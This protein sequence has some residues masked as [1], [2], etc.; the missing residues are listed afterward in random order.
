MKGFKHFFSVLPLNSPLL[1]VRGIGVRDAMPATMVNRVSGTGDY[2]FA[3]FH[4]AVWLSSGEMPEPSPGG[5]LMIWAPKQWQCYGNRAAPFRHSWMHCDGTAVKRLLAE[6]NLPTGQPLRIPDPSIAERHLLAIFEELTRQAR[7]DVMIVRNELDNMLRETARALRPATDAPAIPAGFL[8]AR[9][10]IE[11]EYERSIPLKELAEKA[12]CS[13]RHFGDMFR[14]HFG[15]PP[16]EYLQR[17]R[18]QR[19]AYLLRDRNLTI[20]GVA[21]CVGYRNIHFFSVAFKRYFG[22]APGAFRKDHHY[23][24]TAAV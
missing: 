4:D 13:V 6:Q 24:L 11:S 3:Y 20:K 22:V 18:L 12:G 19:A 5:T 21:H 23:Q 7:P 9:H 14:R 17:H 10:L 2:L 15:M 8:A 1:S 16:H